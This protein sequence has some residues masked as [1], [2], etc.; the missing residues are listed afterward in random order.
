MVQETGTDIMVLGMPWLQ[1]ITEVDWKKRTV[2][3]R[4]NASRNKEREI[5]T[6]ISQLKRVKS[7]KKDSEK[8]SL[9]EENRRGPRGGYGGDQ[10]MKNTKE[11]KYQQ[12]L[13][14]TREKLPDELKE[15]AEVFCQK[16]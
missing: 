13:K 1:E 12:E 6:P 16:E 9:S 11:K 8:T 2:T 4:N 14:E 15:Y 3:L 7:E 10:A 5:E